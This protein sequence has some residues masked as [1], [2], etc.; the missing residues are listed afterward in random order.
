MDI[1]I[2][3]LLLLLLQNDVEIKIYFSKYQDAV[4]DF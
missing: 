2:W 4:F 3:V 1:V